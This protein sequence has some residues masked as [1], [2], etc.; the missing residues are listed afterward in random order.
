MK[1]WKPRYEAVRMIKKRALRK[2]GV[3]GGEAVIE[4]VVHVVGLLDLELAELNGR[5]ITAN[6]HYMRG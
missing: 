2:D 5:V 1:P 4:L 6:Y 3:G